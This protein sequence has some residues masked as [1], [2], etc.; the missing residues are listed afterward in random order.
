LLD[1]LKGLARKSYALDRHSRISPIGRS[2]AQR[3]PG[4]SRTVS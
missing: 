2:V 1:L 4:S 3:M